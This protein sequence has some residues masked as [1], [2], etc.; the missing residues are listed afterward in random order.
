M[1]DSEY[2]ERHWH[3]VPDMLANTGQDEYVHQHHMIFATFVAVTIVN[4]GCVQRS[5]LSHDVSS[6]L[7]HGVHGFQVKQLVLISIDAH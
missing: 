2:A 6:D 1:T 3:M 4:L 7:Q 5:L